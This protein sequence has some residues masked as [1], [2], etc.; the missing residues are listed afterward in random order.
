MRITYTTKDNVIDL[1]CAGDYLVV[2]IDDNHT[3][4]SLMEVIDMINAHIPVMLK[5]NSP[6]LVRR[7][8][9]LSGGYYVKH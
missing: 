9:Q 4:F 5:S 1:A 8:K 3:E 7:A 2:S 6:G